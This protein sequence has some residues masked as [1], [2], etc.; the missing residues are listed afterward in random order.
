VARLQHRPGLDLYHS[1]LV[2]RVPGER[3]TIEMA[4]IPDAPWGLRGVVAEGPVGS[5][6]AAWLRIFRYEVR[7]WPDG[8]ISDIDE[9]VASP[10]L[11]TKDPALTRRVLELASKVPTPVWGR[12]ELGAGG[13]WNSNSVI[14]WL[15]ARS[16]LDVDALR[17]PTGGRAPDWHAGVEVARRQQSSP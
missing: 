13:M 9:A 3:F 12:D 1:A 16:G 11:L 10:R 8:V 14:S 4:P 15:V 6:R 2:V 5:S 17:P 7:C